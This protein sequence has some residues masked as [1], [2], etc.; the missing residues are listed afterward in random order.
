[1][2]KPLK[3]MEYV[4]RARQDYALKQ[5]DL[6]T[7][8]MSIKAQSPASD[9]NSISNSGSVVIGSDYT[10]LRNVGNR[11]QYIRL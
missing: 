9:P 4:F 1:M 8:T 6:S 11:E 3:L 7:K 10:N 5:F 2:T